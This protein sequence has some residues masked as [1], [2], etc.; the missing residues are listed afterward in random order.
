MKSPQPHTT[1]S[2]PITDEQV[3]GLA[4]LCVRYRV[5]RL[6]LFGSAAKGRFD[7][8]HSDFDFTV[9]FDEP[10]GMSAMRQYFGFQE[11]AAA[12][13]GRSVDLVERSAIRNPYFRQILDRDEVVIYGVGNAQVAL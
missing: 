7:P 8:T 1:L 3:R 6:G 10:V 4:A 9:D 13:L 2:L 11:D 12:L 5:R